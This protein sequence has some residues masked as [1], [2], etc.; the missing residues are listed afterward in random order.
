MSETT[1]NEEKSIA[2]NTHLA[3]LL[4]YFIALA[5][6]LTP[7]TAALANLITPIIVWFT[8]QKSKYVKEQAVEAA[9]FQVLLSAL[10]FFILWSFPGN[11]TA[12]KLF[13]Y[14]SYTGIGLYHLANL[15][16]AT[17]STSYGKDFKHLFS[18]F[19]FF[20]EKHESV[21]EEKKILSGL[22]GLTKSIY[23]ETM[24]NGT[25]R[26]LEIASLATKVQDPQVKAKTASIVEALQAIMEDFKKDPK[27]VMNSRHFLTYT[28]D[29]LVTILQKYTDI[30][31]IAP[32]KNMNETLQK[33][34]PV[35]ETIHTAIESHHKK[36]LEDDVREL[37][38]EIEVMQKTIQMGGF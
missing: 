5:P 28:M 33:V 9:F 10:F 6:I 20:K 37:D 32:D 4:T 31:K 29:T 26:L 24:K 13:R 8:N 22:D 2:R 19:R 25:A 11:D 3:S 12:D 23:T 15:L 1:N 36:L 17:I 18:P 35:L 14:L 7:A 27:D 30:S 16:W 38:A 21:L 34:L